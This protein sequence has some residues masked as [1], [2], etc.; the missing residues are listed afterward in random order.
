[1]PCL[2]G[3]VLGDGVRMLLDDRID[4]LF[5]LS[6]VGDLNQALLLNDDTPEPCLSCTSPP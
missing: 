1:M 6:G 3:S 4:N 2:A 5:K